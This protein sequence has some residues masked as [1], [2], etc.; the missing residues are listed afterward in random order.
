MRARATGEARSSGCSRTALVAA[1]SGGD[2]RERVGDLILLQLRPRRRHRSV[3]TLKFFDG[4]GM[5]VYAKPLDLRPSR[6]RGC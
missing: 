6:G 2:Y 5:G 4:T 3:E 1:E